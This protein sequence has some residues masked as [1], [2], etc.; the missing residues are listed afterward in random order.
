MGQMQWL[1]IV[2]IR[3]GQTQ[4]LA[5]NR[6]NILIIIPKIGLHGLGP[7]HRKTGQGP[8]KFT[9]VQTV[10][11]IRKHI[12][13]RHTVFQGHET[14]KK[15]LLDPAILGPVGTGF[16]NGE[17]RHQDD[18]QHFIKIMAVGI[19]VSGIGDPLKIWEDPI[20]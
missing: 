16:T 6:N 11:K 13:A 7:S 20:I 12:M 3:K 14:T 15:R 1:T 5:V 17:N 4:S 9:R 18:Q 8:A 10:E 19:A 2:R